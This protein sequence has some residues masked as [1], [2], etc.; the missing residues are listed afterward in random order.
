MSS[1]L[2]LYFVI[3]YNVLPHPL[4]QIT[5]TLFCLCIVLSDHEKELEGVGGTVYFL[6]RESQEKKRS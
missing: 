5:D 2:K 6:W 1:C 4:Q 3:Q